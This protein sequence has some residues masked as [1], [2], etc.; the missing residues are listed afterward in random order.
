MTREKTQ[1]V[2]YGIASA[3]QVRGVGMGCEAPYLRSILRI[4][5]MDL[6]PRDLSMNLHMR[7]FRVG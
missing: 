4:L 7:P 2:C 1:L 3:L 6:A 5:R